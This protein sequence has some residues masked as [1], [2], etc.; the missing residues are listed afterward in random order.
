MS[1]L[2]VPSLSCYDCL[3]ESLLEPWSHNHVC[4]SGHISTAGLWSGCG[5]FSLGFPGPQTMFGT[6]YVAYRGLKEGSRE[7][8]RKKGKKGGI[9]KRINE[10]KLWFF[11]S[12]LKR[13][14]TNSINSA[15]ILQ[16]SLF[17]IFLIKS[18]VV[19]KKNKNFK[20]CGKIHRTKSHL[21][22]VALSIFT[23]LCNHL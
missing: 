9:K 17:K 21:S 11:I 3:R 4:L 14:F 18:M 16:T 13:S 15:G 20:K 5:I 22:S 19:K 1:V 12:D 10:D 23:F 8:S 6:C 7:T 2:G